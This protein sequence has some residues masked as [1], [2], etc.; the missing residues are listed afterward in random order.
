M[1][2]P[3]RARQAR[4]ALHCLPLL[5]SA[6]RGPQDGGEGT[7]RPHRGQPLCPPGRRPPTAPH[8]TEPGT[9]GG[10]PGSLE[11]PCRNTRLATVYL[12]HSEPSRVP[13]G[14]ESWAGVPG[15]D[16]GPPAGART[17]G[18]GG[19]SA[20][21]ALRACRSLAEDARWGRQSET[22][23]RTQLQSASRFCHR[24]PPPAEPWPIG[25]RAFFSRRSDARASWAVLTLGSPAGPRGWRGALSECRLHGAPWA[26]SCVWAGVL[27]AAG[28][29]VPG[30]VPPF[31]WAGNPGGVAEARAG[32]G[33]PVR[34]VGV[35][36]GQ[37]VGCASPCTWRRV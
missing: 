19:P 37:G 32:G 9:R 20:S 11:S 4:S 18:E 10:C 24:S 3:A 28:R 7:R 36:A 34:R 8:H 1:C 31:T 29:A 12:P 27:G 26:E 22:S 23:A 6:L 2:G 30:F 35:G 13:S 17:P 21:H 14:P 16:S 15:G 5:A 25:G 33:V